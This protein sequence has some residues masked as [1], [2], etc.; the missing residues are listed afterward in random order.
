[1]YMYIYIHMFITFPYI[2]NH[3]YWL[4]TDIGCLKLDSNFMDWIGLY[5]T[6]LISVNYGECII[7]EL[8]I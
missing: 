6:K 4:H 5:I 1:M 3:L 7:P 8:I 2:S